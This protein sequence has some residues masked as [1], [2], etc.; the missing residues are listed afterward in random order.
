[1]SK[2]ITYNDL[3]LEYKVIGNGFK[4]LLAFHGFGRSADDFMVF[5]K[6]F[7]KSYKV[8]AVNL[9]GHGKSRYPDSRIDQNTLSIAELK[10]IIQ[11]LLQ[12]EAIKKF[13]LVGYSLG[14]KIALTLTEIFASRVEQLFL[15][16]PDGIVLNNW[17]KLASQNILGQ[18][19]YK[20]I[21]KNPNWYFKIVRFLNET[22]LLNDKLYKFVVN[23]MDTYEKRKM[24][25]DVWMIFRNIYPNLDEVIQRINEEQI[26]VAV[27][28][29]K[30]DKIITPK[31]AHKLVNKLNE[32]YVYRLVNTGHNLQ[33]PL[34]D[35]TLERIIH[36]NL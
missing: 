36:E 2:H 26:F 27:L 24:V 5:E 16:A 17:Y 32:N 4:P 18:K 23:H 21:T 22:K 34:V 7:L 14:G 6:S 28:I 35:K 1:M 12:E 9:F 30:H 13:S 19:L 33:T 8:I 29:G 11:L 15:L 10:E 3:S 31:I 25:Y 20:Y